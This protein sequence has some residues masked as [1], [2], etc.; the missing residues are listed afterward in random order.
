[1]L[2]N[3]GRTPLTVYLFLSPTPICTHSLIPP[4]GKTIIYVWFRYGRTFCCVESSAI[5][6]WEFNSLCSTPP[7][8]VSVWKCSIPIPYPILIPHFCVSLCGFCWKIEGTKLNDCKR[9]TPSVGPQAVKCFFFTKTQIYKK[10]TQPQ[11]KLSIWW[12]N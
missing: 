8:K 4:H 6:L 5:V 2:I 10:E 7:T 3:A 9:A 12:Q 1:M 11:I